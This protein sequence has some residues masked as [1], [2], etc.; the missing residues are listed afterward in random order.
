MAASTTCSELQDGEAGDKPEMPHVGSHH[1]VADFQRRCSDQQIAE[2]NDDSPALLLSVDLACQ[3]CRLFGVG[4]DFHV[5]E[6]LT[7]EE[8][9]RLRASAVCA[10]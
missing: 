3:Q 10:R 2:R 8:S 5:V 7:D 9:R 1:R 4:I 6:Q